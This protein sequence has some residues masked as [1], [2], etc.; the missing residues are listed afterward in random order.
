MIIMKD[1]INFIQYFSEIFIMANNI[2]LHR[3]AFDTLQDFDFIAYK[4]VNQNNMVFTCYNHATLHTNHRTALPNL[5]TRDQ[6]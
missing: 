6:Y 5:H 3:C 4:F 1:G 2:D